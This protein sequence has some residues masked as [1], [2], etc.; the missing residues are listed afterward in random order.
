MP[1]L[2]WINDDVARR[3]GKNVPFHLLEKQEHYGDPD[4]NNMLIQG[5]NL[6]ALRALLPFYKGKVKCIY[7]DP[8]YNTG[9]AFEHYDDNLEHS[10]WL[11]L[12]VPRLQL[13]R[14]F[15]TEDGSIWVSIDDRESH[16]LK[17]LM[18]EIFGRK[19]FIGDVAWQR[20]YSTRNDSK[21][22]CVEVEHMLAYSKSSPWTPGRLPRTSEM[23]NKYKNPDND[24]GPWKNSDAFAPGASTHQ[25]MVYAVQN[26]FTGD[27]IYPTINRHWCY[28]QDV[29]LSIMQGWGDYELR[30]LNDAQKRA[31]ICGVDVDSVKQDVYGIALKDSIEA[32]SIRAMK[33]LKNGPWPNFYF[34]KNGKGGLSRKIY[35]KDVGDRLATNLWLYEEVG[36][37]DEAKKEIRK[38]FDHEV[39]DTPKPERLI[40]RVLSIATKEGDLVLDSFL[41][42]GTT[43]AVSQKMGRRY[44]G[45][46]MGEHAQT[47]CLPRLK[48]VIDGEQGGISKTVG[49]NG[50]GGFSFYKVGAP[51]FDEFGLI[52][53]KVKF[54][55]L[56]AYV[57]QSETGE[58]SQP[59]KSPFLGEK[60]GVGVYLLFHDVLGSDDNVLNYQRLK[61]LLETH[62][63][64][65]EKV[66]Y[67][68]ACVGISDVELKRLQVTFKQIP[69]DIK[70]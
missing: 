7:I 69:F 11:S 9:S 24:S 50:G 67:A 66:I 17:V 55:T 5:D 1:F 59:R 63:F 39:F 61:Q 43:V 32:A 36:H 52:N 28:G 6:I 30:D 14:E 47:H 48:K 64:D 10:Q 25:G 16:Y 19:N 29:V 31:Q 70:Q 37:T 51:V 34:T 65:G 26:P 62:P 42:S 53:P 49:W 33:I 41:G 27:F 35:L 40:Q 22:L 54:E 4:S 46:E 60:N 15:L 13:L 20:T 21:G 12:M 56:A 68:D 2:N 23:N 38:L 3:Q 18:D 45:I 8:P 44:I 57:W 58:P